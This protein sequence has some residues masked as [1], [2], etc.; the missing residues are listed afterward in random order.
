MIPFC[1]NKGGGCHEMFSSVSVEI[2]LAVT[3]V[4]GL[5]G[6]NNMCIQRS[7]HEQHCTIIIITREKT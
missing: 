7:S 5:D 4:G 1:S 3:L 2:A 6:A